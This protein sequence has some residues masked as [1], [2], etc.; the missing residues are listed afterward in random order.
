MS[1]KKN[2]NPKEPLLDAGRGFGLGSRSSLF[3]TVPTEKGPVVLFEGY[4]KD[5]IPPWEDIGWSFPE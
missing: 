2:V 3:G 4:P 1:A 5:Y